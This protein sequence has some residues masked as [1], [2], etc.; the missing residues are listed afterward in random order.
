MSLTGWLLAI[1]YQPNGIRRSSASRQLN[2]A[3]SLGEES[4]DG[5]CGCAALKRFPHSTGIG[6]RCFEARL[7]LYFLIPTSAF[8]AFRSR[9]ILGRS[10]NQTKAT[11]IWYRTQEHTRA[12][13]ESTRERE[14]R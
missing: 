3:K 5:G 7:L 11:K 12:D 9:V 4:P 10:E 8:G 1:G 14:N 2:Y 6:E 13:L